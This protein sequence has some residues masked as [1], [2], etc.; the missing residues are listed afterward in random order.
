MTMKKSAIKREKLVLVILLFIC[1][2]LLTL[3]I[4]VIAPYLSETLRLASEYPSS[5]D[6]WVAYVILGG[7][8][9]VF[10]ASVFILLRRGIRY[11]RK[12][13]E[14]LEI[15]DDSP[16]N[17]EDGNGRDPSGEIQSRERIWR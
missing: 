5:P 8:I 3:I 16:L 12:E 10:I 1:I 7:C 13:G 11:H 17:E 4:L 9:L 2:S 15:G 6:S 14:E